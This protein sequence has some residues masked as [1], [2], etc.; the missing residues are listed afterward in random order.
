MDLLFMAFDY[1]VLASYETLNI[2][3]LT[4]I[5]QPSY[6]FLL[7]PAPDPIT[8]ASSAFLNIEPIVNY[9]RYTYK[10]HSWRYW[11][12]KLNSVI[13]HLRFYHFTM[14]VSWLLF[15]SLFLVSAVMSIAITG[16]NGSILQR[17]SSMREFWS[18]FKTFIKNLKSYLWQNAIQIFCE[19]MF[20]RIYSSLTIK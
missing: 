7:S 10:L 15:F 14:Q 16:L 3:R 12:L 2:T 8:S 20:C 11:A 19:G 18:R 5:F 9:Y 13:K 17:T 6:T 1:S 4:N